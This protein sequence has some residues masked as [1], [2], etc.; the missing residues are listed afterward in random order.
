MNSHAADAVAE[1][2]AGV[3]AL[4]A[5]VLRLML[6]TIIP[7]VVTLLMAALMAQQ[8]LLDALFARLV[9]AR[10]GTPISPAVR[11]LATLFIYTAGVGPTI[12][13]ILL[14]ATNLSIVITASLAA[15]AVGCIVG[16][17]GFLPRGDRE[18]DVLASLR[19][20]E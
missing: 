5:A 9:G 15:A 1:A 19:F 18:T 10:G 4:V 11:F 6:T 14:S 16:A 13:V 12:A 3:I 17:A 8:A 7:F 2:F 20:W